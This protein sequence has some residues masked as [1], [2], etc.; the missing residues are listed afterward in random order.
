MRESNHTSVNVIDSKLSSKID[1]YLGILIGSLVSMTVLVWCIVVAFG[2]LWD[3]HSLDPFWWKALLI[4]FLILSSVTDGWFLIKSLILLIRRRHPLGISIAVLQ[5]MVP[6]IFRPVIS[7]W[8]LLHALIGLSLGI[9]IIVLNM[10]APWYGHLLL[11]I[12]T[13]AGAYMVY[14]F[15]LLSVTAFTKSPSILVKTLHLRAWWGGLACL[16]AF[17]IPYFGNR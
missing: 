7:L 16:V 2:S 4:F 13:G 17:L 9:G 5:P 8:W 6:F 3:I 1:E 10:H 12:L 14:V 11:T 15:V